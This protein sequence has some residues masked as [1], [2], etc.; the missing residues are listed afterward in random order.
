MTNLRYQRRLAAQLLKCGV[1][2]VRIANDY[3][4]DQEKVEE[5]ITRG[6]IRVLIRWGVITKRPKNG[7]S[8]GRHRARQI[9]RAKGRQRGHGS[10]KGASGARTPRKQSWMNRIRAQRQLLSQLRD[11]EVLERSK[12]RLYYRRAK[13]GMYHSR[14]HLLSHLRSEGAI[15]ADFE[16]PGTGGGEN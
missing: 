8:R 5:A 15:P 1:H 7:I 12:Y 16:M 11:S 9:Q 6:D 2:R 10:R 14:A 13:G 3:Q 4:Q